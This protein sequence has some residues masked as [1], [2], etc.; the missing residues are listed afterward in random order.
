V[1]FSAFAANPAEQTEKVMI[2]ER[3]QSTHWERWLYL[4]IVIHVIA[5]T[6]IPYLVRFNLPLDAMEG[7][8]WG[9]QLQ[10]GYDKNPFLNGWL[11]GLASFLDNYTGWATYL[12]SQL[13]VAISFW[14]VWE[15]GKKILTEAYALLGVLLLEGV[16]YYNL[17]AID[18]NDNT[19][20]LALWPL[21]SLYFYTAL[22]SQRRRD[23]ILTGTFAAL[24]MMTKYYTTMLLLP[25]LVFLLCDA[26]NRKSLTT[27]APYFGLLT[28][29]VIITPH[30]VWL[31]THHFI[32]VDYALARVTSDPE[33]LSHINFASFFSARQFETFIPAFLLSLFLVIGKKPLLT[34]QRIPINNFDKQFL[35]CVGVAPFLLTVLIS[36]FTGILLRAGWGQPLL[37]FWGLILVAWVQPRLTTARFIAFL[38]AL[39]LLIGS[40]L[41]GYT[42]ALTRASEPSS[43]NFPGQVIARTLTHEWHATYHAPLPYVAGSRWIAGNIAFYSHDHPKVYI[44]WSQKSSPWIDESI[45]RNKGA[46]FVWDTAEQKD[47]PPEVLARFA[48]LGTVKIMHFSWLRNRAEKPIVIAVAFLAPQGNPFVSIT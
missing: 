27:S 12:F 29:L 33:W 21:I 18:F 35:F 1:I 4:I 31:C 20:E 41:G 38:T 6:L 36:V 47:L 37:C 22:K 11:S 7:A 17:H 39:F 28:F 19:L 43:A 10:W 14:A 15:V 48:E 24:G 30:F 3:P 13:S 44:D 8:V 46:I 26:Q 2:N 23:W 5:W 40:T 42:I 34:T 32:T 16:Q 9:Q 25:M 45:L